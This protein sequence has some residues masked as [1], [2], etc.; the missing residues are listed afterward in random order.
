MDKRRLVRVNRTDGMARRSTG[1]AATFSPAGRGR[2]R[3][4]MQPIAAV[5]SNRNECRN[6]P[7]AAPQNRAGD[8]NTVPVAATRKHPY[9]STKDRTPPLEHPTSIAVHNSEEAVRLEQAGRPVRRQANTVAQRRRLAPATVCRSARGGSLQAPNGLR[10]QTA[11]G[12]EALQSAAQPMSDPAAPAIRAVLSLTSQATGKRCTRTR[13]FEVAKVARRGSWH[14][15]P[16]SAGWWWPD[17]PATDRW[18]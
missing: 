6:A 13:D 12:P 1:N 9:G 7:K 17:S 18:L 4:S 8:G 10:R 14:F 16:I 15:D 11:M 3:K 2:S 5:G